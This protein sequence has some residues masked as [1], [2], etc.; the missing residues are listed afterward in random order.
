MFNPS[1]IKIINPDSGSGFRV[2]GLIRVQGSSQIIWDLGFR[3]QGFGSW[4]GVLGFR[5]I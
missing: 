4:V 2:Y 3:F 1:T 5:L